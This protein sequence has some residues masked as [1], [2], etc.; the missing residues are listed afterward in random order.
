[1]AI[2]SWL[3]SLLLLLSLEFAGLLNR[4]AYLLLHV[5][6]GIISVLA[7]KIHRHP[8]RV[9]PPGVAALATLGRFSKA[10]VGQFTAQLA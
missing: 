10:S 1:V 8:N 6:F 3:L 9:L 4:C 5:R 2:H 7:R